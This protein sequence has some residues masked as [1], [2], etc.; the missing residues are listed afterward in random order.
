MRI[1]ELGKYYPPYVGGIENNTRHCCVELARD[2]D[3]SALVFHT[4]RRTVRDTV[5]GIPV[6]RVGSL[7][8]IASQEIAPGL[9]RHLRAL[10]PDVIHL[11]APNVV[12]SFVYLTNMPRVPIVVTHHT[13]IVR[14]RR[15]R[16]FV[17]PMYRRILRRA[18]AVVVYTRRYA[19]TSPEL[20][21]VLPRIEVIPH[22][23]R[24]GDFEITPE[25]ERLAREWRAGVAGD[26][27][28]IS[29]IGRHVYYKGIDVLLA[30]LARL[31]GV[32]AF[33]GGDGPEVEANRGR[34]LDLGVA[35]RAHFLGPLDREGTVRVYLGSDAFVLPAVNRTE[36]FGQ[37]Q[38]EA[39]L[40]GLPVVVTDVA[41]GV[42]EVTRDGETGIVVPPGDPDA[43]AGAVSRLLGD[44]SLRRRLG[45]AGRRRAR[46]TYVE[47]VTGPQI[48]ALFRRIERRLGLAGSASRPP[49]GD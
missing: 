18:E 40:C 6:V 31:P 25:R 39:Q 44:A 24:A 30:A 22:G 47:S 48:R 36:S 19:E 5:D 32:H 42:T 37:V 41:S 10:A 3:V 35:E 13:D 7:A 11:H 2:H 17:L 20:A 14:Q 4:G 8:K 26:A 21:E 16:P 9:G 23:T 43:L 27:G 33:L 29:F 46:T 12:A 49:G 15:L 45:E 38:V 34:A 28:T 1:V